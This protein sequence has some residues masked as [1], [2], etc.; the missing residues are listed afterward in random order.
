MNSWQVEDTGSKRYAVFFTGVRGRIEYPIGKKAWW[1]I[2]PVNIRT[3]ML[4]AL[5]QP[6]P[7][8]KGNNQCY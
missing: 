8:C 1:H 7:V 2:G 6:E 4:A 5:T 3:L